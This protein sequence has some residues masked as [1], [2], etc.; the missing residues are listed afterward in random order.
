MTHLLTFRFGLREEKEAED[1]LASTSDPNVIQEAHRQLSLP[2]AH[3]WH[4][5]GPISRVLPGTN[6][7]WSWKHADSLWQFTELSIELCDAKPS[8]I[9]LNLDE[10]LSHVGQACPWS[11]FVK[12]EEDL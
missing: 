12:R 4:I 8:H 1:F 11:S 5:S 9:E 7:G 3:R 2:V 10:W 6:L